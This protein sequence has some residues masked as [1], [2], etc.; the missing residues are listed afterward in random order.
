[1]IDHAG[2]DSDTCHSAAR[3]RQGTDGHDVRARV[4]I[5]LFNVIGDSTNTPGSTLI[6]T[7]V[8]NVSPKPK[9]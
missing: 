3:L 2:T 1:V 6:L 4:F 5:D 8:T 9:P 7:D